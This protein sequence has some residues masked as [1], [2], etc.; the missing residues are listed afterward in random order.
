EL[1]GRNGGISIMQSELIRLTRRIYGE[2]ANSIDVLGM[3]EEC[4]MINFRFFVNLY[5]AKLV[6]DEMM[7]AC[8]MYL[9]NAAKIYGTVRNDA[10]KLLERLQKARRNRLYQMEYARA[11]KE[12]IETNGQ[13]WLLNEKSEESR[14]VK[15]TIQRLA[16]TRMHEK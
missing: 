7:S 3:S 11:Y 14:I 15:E 5:Q 8:I 13:H 12:Y 1:A 9:E 2:D 6:S 10:P 16:I 4:R